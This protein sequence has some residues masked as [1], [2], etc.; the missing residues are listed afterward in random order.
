M[1]HGIQKPYYTGVN[2]AYSKQMNSFKIRGTLVFKNGTDIKLDVGD[3]KILSISL[4]GELN[5]K[6]GDT[7]VIDKK[8]YPPFKGRGYHSCPHIARGRGE[9]FTASEKHGASP[10]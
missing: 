2:Q 1:Y 6:L 4:K 7:V 8:K 5:A 9:I 10:A 3:Q